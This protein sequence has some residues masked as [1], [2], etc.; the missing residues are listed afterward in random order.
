MLCFLN[1]LDSDSYLE[2]NDDEKFIHI[3]RIFLDDFEGFNSEKI[4]TMLNIV[5]GFVNFLDNTSSGS[6]GY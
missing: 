5:D 1:K 3:R 6:F 4:K 2:S